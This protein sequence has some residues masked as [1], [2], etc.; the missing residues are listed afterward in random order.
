MHSEWICCQIGA[1]EHYAV[2][3]VLQ[4]SGRLRRFYTDFWAGSVVRKLAARTGANLLRS[5]ATRFHPDLGGRQGAVV[6][7]WN[8]RSLL[9]EKLLR[10]KSSAQTPYEGFIEVG[11]R[12][13]R[14]VREDLK[15]RQAFSSDSIF[16]AYDTGALEAM[17]WCRDRNIK[18]V[19]NQMDPN[20]VEAGLVGEEEKRWPGWAIN[21]LL[22]PEE[23]FQRRE[24]EWV[25]ADRV[26]VNSEF[27]RQALLTQGVPSKKVVVIPLC[28][29]MDGRSK[30][31]DANTII[32]AQSPT[33]P[34]RILFLGQVIL[35]KGIQYVLAAAQKLKGENVRFDMVGKIGISAEAVASAPKSVHFHGPSTRD[36]A[37]GWYRQ[38]DVFVLPTISDGFAITQVEAMAYGL[39][40]V[41]TAS[42]GDVV[43]D[44]VDGFVVPIRDAE[45]LAKTLLRYLTEPGL[46]RSQQNAALAKAKQF[47]LERLAGNL[48]SL[49][50]RLLS[51]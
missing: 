45:A 17:A 3:R 41:T 48:L 8:S 51:S 39:P 34:L 46:L 6:R 21:P 43:S 20:R 11:S 29:E 4:R 35:R 28:F 12:F 38:A 32:S 40:V 31:G 25:L 7:S 44:D 2:P 50:E 13:A 42:C 24:R 10:K 49:E 47:T 36:Q 26:V 1:R 37:A 15:R 5:L 22:I 30:D 16:F 14:C 27:C 9:W 19:L 23:Y 18:C 33:A